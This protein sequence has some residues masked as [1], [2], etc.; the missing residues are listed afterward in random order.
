M[1]PIDILI[2]SNGP[3]ELATWVQ[4]TV[5]ALRDLVGNDEAQV[6]ISLILSPC[7][8]ATGQEANLARQINAINRVQAAEHFWQFLLVGKTHEGWDWRS[9]GVVLFLGGDQL[10]T[11]LVSR[12]LGYAS[13]AYAEWEARW[14]PWIT[15]IGAMNTKVLNGAPQRYHHKISIVGD[16]IPEVN[17]DPAIQ[18]NQYRTQ[19]AL[20]MSPNTELIGLLPGSKAS[21]LT[22]GVPL[23]LAIAQ[24]L[25]RQ[26]PQTQFVIPVAPTLSLE[27]LAQ[28]ADPQLNPWTASFD[29]TTARLVTEATP[30]YLETA[31]G[32][33]VD[34]WTQTPYY[35]LFSLC[36]FCLTSVGA[37]TAELGSL[38]VPM[39]VLLPTQQL[40]AM[41]SW[42][43]LPGLLANLPGVGGYFAKLIN[44]VA[45]RYLGLLAWPNI[46]AGKEIVP[47]LLGQLDPEEVAKLGLS[48][49]E[50]PEKLQ[51][52]R[53]DLQNVRGGSGAAMKLAHLV[54][55]QL[56]NQ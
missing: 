36:K 26:R 38:G 4:P 23:L 29:G 39:I 18:D 55:D 16:L 50:D 13:V 14:L 47:E 40:D 22:Q 6:R 30:P 33:R 35:S 5:R 34:L 48:W 10:F 31:Q 43:G 53:Q 1:Q 2:L 11:V 12:R 17:A 28:Y 52:I 3:G 56:S 24:H 9:R 44:W 21:K 51:K 42:D 32:L 54:V 41:R 27:A 46:W 20:R 15:A 8:H 19:E 45:I 25:H 7:P 49:L 37:N